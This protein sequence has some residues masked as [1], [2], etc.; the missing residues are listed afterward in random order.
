MSHSVT[1][2]FALCVPVLPLPSVKPSARSEC[3][4]SVLLASAQ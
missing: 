1:L 2:S 3:F 4:V